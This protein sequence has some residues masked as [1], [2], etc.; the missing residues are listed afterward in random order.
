MSK[1]TEHV[2]DNGFELKMCEEIFLN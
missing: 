2:K 1:Y